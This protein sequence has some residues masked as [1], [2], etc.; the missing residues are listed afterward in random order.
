MVTLN[1]HSDLNVVGFL[2]A[3]TNHLANEGISVNVVSAYFHD[4]L[5]VNSDKVEK[6]MEILNSLSNR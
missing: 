5:F 1:V 6:V 3:I 2:E 4:H